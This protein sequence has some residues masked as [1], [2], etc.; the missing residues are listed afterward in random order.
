LYSQNIPSIL[1]LKYHPHY[2]LA[3]GGSVEMLKK[4]L[5]GTP[6]D[7][8]E[9][10]LQQAISGCL[11]Y[12]QPA[13]LDVLVQNY[14]LSSLD[15]AFIFTFIY[16]DATTQLNGMSQARAKYEDQFS[17]VW[18]AFL[19][20]LDVGS[21]AGNQKVLEAMM[22]VGLKYGSKDILH[23]LLDKCKVDLD[24]F[25]VD[26]KSIIRF[27]VKKDCPLESLKIIVAHEKK[28]LGLGD[29]A[30]SPWLDS[31]FLENDGYFEDLFRYRSFHDLLFVREN[32]RSSTWTGLWGQVKDKG[33]FSDTALR[34]LTG[35]CWAHDENAIQKLVEMGMDLNAFYPYQSSDT[36]LY[37]L[38][39]EY[40]HHLALIRRVLE[41]GADPEVPYHS[42]SSYR[43]PSVLHHV[44][45]HWKPDLFKVIME[46]YRTKYESRLEQ[47]DLVES[48]LVGLTK[49]IEYIETFDIPGGITIISE[50][51]GV[52]DPRDI[53]E[54]LQ[55]IYSSG[56]P[57]DVG[58]S[59]L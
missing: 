11:L 10:S 20:E 4:K 26:N 19:S 45:E 23:Y 37:A 48:V 57:G 28:K 7:K 31:Y 22:E 49:A 56:Q 41:M 43:G 24:T 1:E 44:V 40:K 2:Y 32:L 33:Y 53:T 16:R 9:D 58:S 52:T 17:S 36:P 39:Q 54:E 14:P 27:F 35:A 47:P 29:S 15:V 3:A 46:S 6:P 42:F 12:G 55:A 18:K 21:T 50:V 30:H 51:F 5:D 8:M 59:R 38:L 13:V 25:Q 34:K